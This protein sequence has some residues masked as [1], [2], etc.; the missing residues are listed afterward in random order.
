[1]G[2]TTVLWRAVALAADAERVELPR[3]RRQSLLVANLVN[4]PVTEV[5][6]V[7]KKLGVLLAK[8]KSQR[9]LGRV[10]M[11][12]V[13]SVEFSE[14]SPPID[15]E[16]MEVGILPAHHY[17]ENL[18]QLGQVDGVLYLY[19]T[20]DQRAYVHQGNFQLINVHV[21]EKHLMD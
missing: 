13:E 12:I 8:G 15:G 21:A 14:M 9:N 5:I 3:L 7:V 2:T 4:P 19:P 6:L 16:P 17:L 18:V 1:M 10:V 11:L 20:P